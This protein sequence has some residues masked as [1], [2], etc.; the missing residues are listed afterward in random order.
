MRP[1]EDRRGLVSRSFGSTLQCH[2]FDDVMGLAWKVE[3]APVAQLLWRSRRSGTARQS[4]RWLSSRGGERR[5][6]GGLCLDVAAIR[7]KDRV[8]QCMG[9][10]W[11]PRGHMVHVRVAV[12]AVGTQCCRSASTRDRNDAQA[13]TV[14]MSQ[15]GWPILSQCGLELVSKWSW[16]ALSSG[17]GPVNVLQ[18][19]KYFPIAFN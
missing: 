6:K 11:R 16:A 12:G 9:Y 15:V 19:S 4:A 14:E 8:V 10:A 7:D 3:E 18:Y 13:H 17:P 5:G 2:C 1:E